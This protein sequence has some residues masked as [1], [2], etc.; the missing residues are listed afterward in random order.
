[1]NCIY[2][3]KIQLFTYTHFVNNYLMFWGE[4]P[5]KFHNTKYFVTFQTSLSSNY[6]LELHLTTLKGKHEFGKTLTLK[7]TSSM[8]SIFV[9]ITQ[10]TNVMNMY[11]ALSIIQ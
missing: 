5:Q 4:F 3:K 2:E 1:M 7:P 10:F 6:I 8:I 9:S 11:D